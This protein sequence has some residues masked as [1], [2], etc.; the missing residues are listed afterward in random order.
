MIIMM[1]MIIMIM[2]IRLQKSVLG[3]FFGA[4]RQNENPYLSDCAPGPPESIEKHRIA[5]R[6]G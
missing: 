5:P 3:D 6:W 2:I 4:N 1:I